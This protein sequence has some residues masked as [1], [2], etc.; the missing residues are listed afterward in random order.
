M[1]N[2][3]LEEADIIEM[4]RYDEENVET[5]LRTHSSIQAYWEALAIRLKT[6]TENFKE[7]WVKKW[8]A[9]HK[10]YAKYILAAY[11][12]TK[13][14]LDSVTDMAVLIYS[15]ETTQMEREK[16]AYLAY[17]IVSKRAHPPSLEDFANSMYKYLYVN[18]PWY[19]ETLIQTQKKLQEEFEIVHKVAERLHSKSFHLDLYAKMMMA[20]RFN[21]G[22][23]DESD[24]MNKIGGKR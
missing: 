11:G 18:P 12:E 4:L 23:I 24:L 19:F 14:T 16:F 17:E 21:I 7:G 20:K 6:R 8:W 10:Q 15:A 13:P 9:Y 22:P 5:L 1:L 2:E 3:N